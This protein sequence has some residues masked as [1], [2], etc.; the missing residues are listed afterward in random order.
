[1]KKCYDPVNDCEISKGSHE[2]HHAV[3]E[4][5]ISYYYD[6]DTGKMTKKRISPSKYLHAYRYINFNRQIWSE[7]LSCVIL[8]IGDHDTLHKIALKGKIG[9][10]LK[11]YERGFYKSIPYAWRSEKNYK[12][13]LEWI[14]V[15]SHNI[16]VSKF[17]SY[18]EFIKVHNSFPSIEP[19]Q[20][21]DFFHSTK[22][23][24]TEQ[25]ANPC[26]EENVL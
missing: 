8:D 21:S 26:T 24:P 4:N 16:D 2:I 22:T 15:V 9:Y 23:D 19:S 3:Y 7:L 12:E 5:G 18:D 13:I 11:G 14:S 1:M 25:N 10:W 6:L 17:L 20:E